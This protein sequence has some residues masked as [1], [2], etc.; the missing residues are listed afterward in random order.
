MCTYSMIHDWAQKLPDQTWTRPM[1][2]EYQEIIRQ[3][4]A[5]DEKLGLPN[6]NPNKGEFLEKIEAR[7]LAIEKRLVQR[8]RAVKAKRTKRR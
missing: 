3:L 7:L 1:F 2:S 8:G 6:C 5:I 4:K